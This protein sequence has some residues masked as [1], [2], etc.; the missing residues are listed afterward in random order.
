MIPAVSSYPVI[1]IR[2][3]K[4]TS[5]FEKFI[6]GI[7]ILTVIL[8]NSLS[9]TAQEFSMEI[10]KTPSASNFRALSVV[11]DSVIWVSGSGSTVCRSTN[12]GRSFQCMQVAKSDSL[13]FRSLYA[14]S[15]TEAVIAS[16]GSPAYILRTVDG[17]ANWV[18]VYENDH[19]D[20]FINGLCFLNERDGFCYGDPIDGK[21]LLERTRDGGH[22]WMRLPPESRPL[23][24]DNEASF[25]ASGTGI[26]YTTDGRLMIATG[27]EISRLLVS[28]DMAGNWNSIITPILQGSKST[29]IFS[30]DFYDAQQGV[31]VGG[32]YLRD[33]VAEKHVF[34]TSDGGSSWHFPETPTRGYRECVTYLNKDTLITAGPSG[35]DFSTDGGRNWKPLSDE[36]GFHVVK[37]VKGK[38][39]VFMAGKNGRV[40]VVDFRKKQKGH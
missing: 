38:P 17:G 3:F 8:S 1:A 18:R 34:Y 30:F 13:D 37:T 10:I 2:E 16:A 25:A 11:N 22:T 6:L 21:M 12:G 28:F 5:L 7:C 31:I 14:F 40:G 33:T 15:D 32:D 4:I 24:V 19:R 27:G 29:G 20:A 35:I 26:R 36:R 9:V 39:V 23:L